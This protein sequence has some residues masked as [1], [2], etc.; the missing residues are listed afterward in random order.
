MAIKYPQIKIYAIDSIGKKIRAVE[1][2][3]KSLELKNLTPICD[4]VENLN[5]QFDVVTSRAVASLDKICAYALPK[6]K[7]NGYFVAFKSKKTQEEIE[8]AQ[9]ILKKYNA[10]I[11]DIIEYQLP[12]KEQTERNL[13]IIQV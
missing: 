5:E 1:S 13:I 3:K 12:L 7:K 9:K 8:S 10:K 11:I 4:R 6:T 2:L